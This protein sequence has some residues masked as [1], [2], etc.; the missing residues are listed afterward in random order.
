MSDE[1]RNT[2]EY[3]RADRDKETQST[4]DAGAPSHADSAPLPETI[5][6]YKIIRS[7]GEGGMGAVYEA[8]Q[9]SP[10]RRVA[11]KVIKAGAISERL[12]KRFEIEAQILG[13]LDHP[14]I[15]TIYEAGTFGSGS[16]AQPFFAMEFVEGEL[17]TDYV[18]GK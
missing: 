10:K 2:P 1:D 7:I 5:G 18:F 3:L 14:G 16:N 9:E 6:H 12:L 4:A 15:A 8:E 17:L 11:L 13:R